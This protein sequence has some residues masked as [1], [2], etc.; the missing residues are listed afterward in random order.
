MALSPNASG[1]ILCIS[2]AIVP[3][4]KQNL[5]QIHC[6]HTPLI[7]PW[8]NHKTALPRHKNAPKKKKHTSTRRML[9]GRLFHKGYSSQYVAANNCTTSGFCMAFQFQGLLGSTSYVPGALLFTD[10]RW[11]R[12][13]CCHYTHT[14]YTHFIRDFG[15]IMQ[16]AEYII[17]CLKGM[18]KTIITCTQTS[19]L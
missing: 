12:T 8:Y 3:S 15:G 18:N 11:Y 14:H 13:V 5:M 19:G 10:H 6:S 4:L 17:T 1:S 16:A 7:L 2:A 9:F